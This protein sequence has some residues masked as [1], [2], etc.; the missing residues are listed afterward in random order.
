MKNGKIKVGVRNLSGAQMTIEDRDKE[1]LSR[2]YTIEQTENG[3][4]VHAPKTK[5]L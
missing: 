3:R 2:G 5:E 4:I 1:L